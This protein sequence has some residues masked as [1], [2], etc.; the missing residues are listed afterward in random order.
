LDKYFQENKYQLFKFIISGLIASSLNFLVF[1]SFYL[2]FKNIILA[3]LVGYSTGLLL[4]FIF[5]K[6]WVFRDN[7]KKKILKSFF[8][9]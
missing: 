8:I 3:S 6:I 2:I 7:S 9:F 5:A 4:S 1:N